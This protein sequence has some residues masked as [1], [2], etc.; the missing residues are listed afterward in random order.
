MLA[1]VMAALTNVLLLIF[2][3]SQYSSWTITEKARAQCTSQSCLHVVTLNTAVDLTLSDRLFR[4]PGALDLRCKADVGR[5]HKGF[6]FC[7]R[8]VPNL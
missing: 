6:D 4:L 5:V 2:T 1:G 8:H 3:S 7:R